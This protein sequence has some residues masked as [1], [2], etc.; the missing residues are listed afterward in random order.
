[1]VGFKDGSENSPGGVSGIEE[2]CA[3]LFI[4][5]PHLAWGYKTAC[6]PQLDTLGCF[7][8]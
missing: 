6:K 4:A 8:T 5:G 3:I 7:V 1:M 2:A